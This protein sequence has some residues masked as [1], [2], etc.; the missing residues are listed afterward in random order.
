MVNPDVLGLT[1]AL[2]L[3]SIVERNEDSIVGKR[4]AVSCI[5][6]PTCDVEHHEVSQRNHSAVD[7]RQIRAKSSDVHELTPSTTLT[8]FPLLFHFCVAFQHAARPDF[9]LF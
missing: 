7:E 6:K 9:N 3:S 2:T 5:D 8:Q 4:A 1:W